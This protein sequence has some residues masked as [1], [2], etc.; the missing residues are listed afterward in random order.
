MKTLLLILGLGLSAVTDAQTNN[1]KALVDSQDYVF[2]AWQ[3]MPMR[4]RVRNLTY[5]Y[6]LK[7]SKQAIVSYLPYYGEAYVAPI[8]PTKNGLEFTSKDYTYTVTPGKKE[9]WT[10]MIKPKDYPEVQQMILNI[11][12][13]GYASL[14]VIS[15]N[16]QAIS[17][18]GA[19][20]PS[21]TTS[22]KKPSKDEK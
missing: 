2:K 8:D 6:D 7:V 9:G 10:V 20:V 17:F 4:G 21:S 13:A 5:D 1:A 22:K 14:Q 16:R 12:S 18:S 19:I 3:A 11:S 15:T